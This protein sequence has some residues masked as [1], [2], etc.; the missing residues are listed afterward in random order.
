[1]MKP[2]IMKESYYVRMVSSVHLKDRNGGSVHLVVYQ[3]H[4][5]VNFSHALRN[6]CEL[7]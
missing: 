1:M 7:L 2:C 6:I 3:I 4:F 5:T